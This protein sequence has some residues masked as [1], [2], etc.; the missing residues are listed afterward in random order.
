MAGI[1]KTN[2]VWAMGFDMSPVGSEVWTLG[3]SAAPNVGAIDST[4]TPLS[5]GKSWKLTNQF[6]IIGLNTN[7]VTLYLGFWVKLTALPG[8]NQRIIAFYDATAV[9]Y[10]CNLRVYSDGHFQ[11]CSGSS[12]TTIGAASSAGLISANVWCHLQMRVTID[13]SAGV[14]ELVVNDTGSHTKQINSTGLNT[15][16][17]ANTWVSGVECNSVTSGSAYFDDMYMLDTT[18]SSPLNSYLGQVQARGEAPSANSATGGHNAWTPTNPQNDNHLN[19]GNAPAN[20]AQ[21]NADQTPG[22]YDMFRFPSLPAVTV[23]FVGV[24]TRCGLD[25]VATKTVKLECDSGGT[26][27]ESAAITPAAIAT[28]TFTNQ[29]FIVDPAT[30]SAWGVTAAGNAELGIKI[31]T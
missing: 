5:F 28:P 22:D 25:G 18:A 30:S 4:N 7:L 31:D 12:A 27:A 10:Q 16:A 6:S 24:W 23:F 14:V 13:S 29:C 26:I 20:T 11:F 1:F 2:G 15:K 19:V 9:N 3:G 21:Y 17:T 8:T